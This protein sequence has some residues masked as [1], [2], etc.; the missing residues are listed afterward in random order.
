MSLTPADV[1]NVAFSRASIDK[2]GYHE[3]EVDGL[4]DLVENHVGQADRGE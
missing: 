3:D 4:L 2:P 1:R